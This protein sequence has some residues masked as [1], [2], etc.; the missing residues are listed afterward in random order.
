PPRRPRGPPRRR[1]PNPRRASR[2]GAGSALA[3][4]P[5]GRARSSARLVR[6]SVLVL[7]EHDVR[8][9]LDMESCIEA[10]TEVLASLARGELYQPLR[11]I[12]RPPGAS[13]LLGL[14]PA[15]RGGAALA[16]APQEICLVA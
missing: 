11:S 15:Y 7:S 13:S 1:R 8:R 3:Q 6:M 14:M 9:L 5:F 16:D 4:T 10:M 2:A 12:A